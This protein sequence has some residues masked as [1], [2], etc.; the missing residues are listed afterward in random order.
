MECVRL[1]GRWLTAN[2]SD[3]TDVSDC[4]DC[5]FFVLTEMCWAFT[6]MK[7]VWGGSFSNK[8]SYNEGRS[9]SLLNVSIPYFMFSQNKFNS[10]ITPNGK[11]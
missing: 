11:V 3:T 9:F 10:A 4:S 1:L 6:W 2:M 7:K 8:L 5:N